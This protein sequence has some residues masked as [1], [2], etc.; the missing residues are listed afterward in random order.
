V[1]KWYGSHV[2]RDLSGRFYYVNFW[3]GFSRRDR[4]PRGNIHG[5]VCFRA[6]IAWACACSDATSQT[7]RKIN[8]CGSPPLRLHNELR[9]TANGARVS[10][11]GPGCTRERLELLTRCFFR[12]RQIHESRNHQVL[13]GTRTSRRTS[14]KIHWSGSANQAVKRKTNVVYLP[15]I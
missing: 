12:I 6:T 11:S 5:F 3:S 1:P 2:G 7:G 14:A 15:R 10:P 8:L 13:R 9:A 4:K